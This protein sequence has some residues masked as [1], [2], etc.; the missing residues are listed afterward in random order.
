MGSLRAA[1]R[2]EIHPGYDLAGM[3][4][5]L[6]DLIHGS[7]PEDAFITL[8]FA[9]L[10]AEGGG[11]R[12]INAG[13]NPPLFYKKDVQCCIL[14]GTGLPLGMLPGTIYEVRSVCLEPG[15]SVMLFTDG[16]I[17]GRD[18]SG[19]EFS[20]VRLKPLFHEFAR[21]AQRDS[22]TRSPQKSVVTSR[23]PTNATT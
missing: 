10:A 1:L 7:S 11:L 4:S 15:D 22:S 12:Y 5:R 21:R 13:H 18:K 17:E 9:E 19:R 8:F 3:F 23:D 20:T 2:S 14:E 6:S 16:V